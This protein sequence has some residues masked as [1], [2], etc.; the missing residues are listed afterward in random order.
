MK[1]PNDMFRLEFSPYLTV[2]DIVN[3]DI[4]CMENRYNY[5]TR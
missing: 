5:L 1:L 2:D 3:L 4:A